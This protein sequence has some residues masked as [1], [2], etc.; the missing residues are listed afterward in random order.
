MTLGFI[1]LSLAAS[2]TLV[3]ATCTTDEC[4]DENAALLQS[5]VK[6]VRAAEELMRDDDA[7]DYDDSDVNAPKFDDGVFQVNPVQ[8]DPVPGNPFQT[9][10]VPSPG[11]P[12]FG[13]CPDY[14]L[15]TVPAHESFKHWFLP[16]DENPPMEEEDFYTRKKKYHKKLKS[17]DIQKLYEDLE[18]LMFTSQDCW[19]ADGPQDG[20]IPNYAGLFERLTWHCSGTFRISGGLPEG[21]CEGGRQRF[22]PENEWIDNENLDKGRGLLAPIKKKYGDSLSWGDLMTF[23]GTVGIK[24][25][26]GPADEFCFGRVDDPDGK[27]SVTLGVDGINGCSPEDGCV[28]TE[29]AITFHWHEQDPTDHP[30]C[31]ATQNN[32]RFQGSHKVGLIYVYPDG[33]Q[34]KMT[35]P[36]V[37]PSW[38]HQRS[39]RLSGLEIRDTFHRMGWND[40]ETVALIAGGHTLGRAHGACSFTNANMQGPYFESQE[41]SG[42]GPTKDGLCGEGKL[43]GFGPNTVSSGFEGPWTRTP[44][45]W[46][47]EYLQSTLFEQWEPALSVYG[48]DQWWTVNRASPNN[49]TMRTTADMALAADDKYRQIAIAYDKNHTLFDQAFAAAW[50]KMVD[51]SKRH[52]GANDL[53]KEAKKS[54]NKCTDFKFVKPKRPGMYGNKR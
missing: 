22:W 28:S 1:L 40:E 24:A 42:R 32:F 54:H 23:A 18:T 36:E 21:G 6:Q 35:E 17:L 14:D 50:R 13:R 43:A 48:G 33:P 27:D 19:P 20:D 4:Q 15:G 29:C 30:M 11:K 25:S 10:P 41:G 16:V 39:A 9:T 45:Q 2:S 46:N 38:V 51:R 3:E 53:K 49:A 31:N 44:S 12:G 34:L 7:A 37:N 26:G 47:Y 8:P 52:P 5:S